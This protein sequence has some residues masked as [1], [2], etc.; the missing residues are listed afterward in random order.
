M[1][2][3]SDSR[4]AVVISWWFTEIR[5]QT[6]LKAATDEDDLMSLGREFHARIV[7]GKNEL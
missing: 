7:E 3:L 6:I 1:Q 4:A 5:I 2:N